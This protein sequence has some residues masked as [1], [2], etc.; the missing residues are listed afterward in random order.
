VPANLRTDEQFVRFA[1]VGAGGLF[2]DMGALWVALRLLGLNLYAG[3]VFSYLIAA[4]FTWACNRSLTFAGAG[5][6]GAVRQWS[7]F[8][9]FNAIGGIVNFAVYVLVAVKLRESYDW[10]AQV[11]AMLPYLGVA[12]G[13]VSGLA[14]NFLASKFFVFR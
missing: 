6:D 5:G 13:S 4:T 7:R 10:T 9:L 8:I 1:A 14:F 12:C 2:V 11:A 3:R